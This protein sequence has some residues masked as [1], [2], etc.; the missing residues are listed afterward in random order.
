MTESERKNADWAW[1]F[2]LVLSLPL[3]WFFHVVWLFVDVAYLV[4]LLVWLFVDVKRIN[5]QILKLKEKDNG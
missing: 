3:G 5:A 2:A 4:W 1:V